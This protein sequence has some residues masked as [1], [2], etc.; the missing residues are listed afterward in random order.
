MAATLRRHFCEILWG[1]LSYFKVYD[2]Q[3]KIFEDPEST[4]FL[5]LKI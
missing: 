4:S 2:V 3:L 5:E 1:S